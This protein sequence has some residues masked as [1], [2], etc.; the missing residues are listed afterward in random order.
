MLPLPESLPQLFVAVA[1]YT[2]VG[3]VSLT[4]LVMALRFLLTPAHT[5]HKTGVVLVTGAATGIGLETV[6]LLAREGY[7]VI[8]GCLNDEQKGDVER[9]ARETQLDITALQLNICC[10]DEVKAALEFV[11]NK[12]REQMLPFVALVNNAAVMS[13][14]PFEV[15]PESQVKASFAV[16]CEGTWRMTSTF[17]PLLREHSARVVTVASGAGHIASSCLGIYSAT[18]HAIEGMMDALRREIHDQGV[19]VSI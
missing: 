5:V 4:L 8:A 19:A 2:A 10:N 12:C 1:V 11:K 14:F 18:K 7:S 17:L 13:F 3:V 6:Q 9:V 16:N 15:T